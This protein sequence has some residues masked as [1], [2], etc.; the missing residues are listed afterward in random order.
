MKNGSRQSLNDD[1]INTPF[2]WEFNQ[3]PTN[4]ITHLTCTK[5]FALQPMDFYLLITISKR[6]T[7]SES[8]NVSYRKNG[9]CK[10]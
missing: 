8:E 3:S 6:G 2:H 7:G 9:D 10:I 4:L 5:F 1:T